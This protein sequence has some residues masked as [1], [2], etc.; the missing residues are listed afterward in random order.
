MDLYVGR[1]ARM[2]EPVHPGLSSRRRGETAQ[3][4]HENLQRALPD[5]KMKLLIVGVRCGFL[6]LDFRRLFHRIV[7]TYCGK[8]RCGTP[9]LL[10]LALGDGCGRGRVAIQRVFRH[11]LV[12]S[13]TWKTGPHESD[14]VRQPAPTGQNPSSGDPEKAAGLDAAA[15]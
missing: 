4:P 2:F 5:M 15:R 12:Q 6:N 13:R 14:A 8:N 7:S 10:R 9:D 1:H 11:G 3:D